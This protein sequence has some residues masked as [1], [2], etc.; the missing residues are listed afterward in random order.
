MG[1]LLGV[2]R[3]TR[4]AQIDYRDGFFSGRHYHHTEDFFL[5]YLFQIQRYGIRRDFPSHGPC[6]VLDIWFNF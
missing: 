1:I 2:S 6:E 3:W 5:R 4:T